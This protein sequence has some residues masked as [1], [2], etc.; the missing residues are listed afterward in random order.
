MNRAVSVFLAVLI[1]A[2]LPLIAGSSSMT[3]WLN[4]RFN[5]E[6]VEMRGVEG[7]RDRI[8]DGKLRLDLHSF[9]E[10]VLRNS[11]AINLERLNVYTQA[12]AITAAKSPL[13]Q[14]LNLSIKATR[15][16][17]PP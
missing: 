11:T 6:T 1:A 16:L 9:L 12:D 8:V 7:L 14:F 13:D 2:P 5:P 4:N 15:T 3:E 10:L 17:E